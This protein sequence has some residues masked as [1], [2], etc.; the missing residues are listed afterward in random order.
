MVTEQNIKEQII[1]DGGVTVFVYWDEQEQGYTADTAN[2]RF[3]AE[4]LYVAVDAALEDEIRQRV[5]Q[6]ERAE[7]ESE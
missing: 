3:T 2:S 6:K 4:N 7:R 1:E 5:I